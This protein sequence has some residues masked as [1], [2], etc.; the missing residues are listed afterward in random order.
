MEKV[1]GN[2]EEG[3]EGSRAAVCTLVPTPAI[4]GIAHWCSKHPN[5]LF[6][7]VTG[8]FLMSNVNSDINCPQSRLDA[9]YTTDRCKNLGRHMQ[10]VPLGTGFRLDPSTFW[11]PVT[12]LAFLRAQF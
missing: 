7:C 2:V 8:G 9:Y 1:V 11:G 3:W 10:P 5:W 4:F 12:A 6:T